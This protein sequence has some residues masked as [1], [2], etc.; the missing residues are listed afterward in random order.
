MTTHITVRLGPREL[1]RL[2]QQVKAEGKSISDFAR[3]RLAIERPLNLDPARALLG[4]IERRAA[5]GKLRPHEL[6]GLREV[7]A[8][9]ADAL[10]RALASPPP[11]KVP[12][13]KARS[14]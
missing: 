8:G 7:S 4:I 3:E 5:D 10:D 6:E 1:T 9:I 14:A 2:R 11:E 13:A 12:A